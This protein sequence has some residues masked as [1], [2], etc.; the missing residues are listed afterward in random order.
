[1][2]AERCHLLANGC[3]LPLIRQQFQLLQLLL[4]FLEQWFWGGLQPVEIFSQTS[5]PLSQVK[6][7]RLWIGPLQ[8]RRVLGW[9]TL[10]VS[11]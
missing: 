10:L 8:F 7:G 2:H 4:P 9:S 11:R 1:M 5:T 3:D 6:N